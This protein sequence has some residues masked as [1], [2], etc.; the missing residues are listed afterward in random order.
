MRRTRER[1]ERDFIAVKFS[2]ENDAKGWG[3]L[4]QERISPIHIIG[5]HNRT[6]LV[7][8]FS[9]ANWIGIQ[10]KLTG[11]NIKFIFLKGNPSIKRQDL[12]N[13]KV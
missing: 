4:D 13:L 3:I 11:E 10:E 9:T 6:E 12:E 2:E 8:V 1:V 5:V 7:Y